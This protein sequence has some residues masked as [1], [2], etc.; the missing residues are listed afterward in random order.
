PPSVS[1]L[2]WTYRPERLYGARIGSQ[3]AP[4]WLATSRNQA[5]RERAVRAVRAER[6]CRARARAATPE[7]ARVGWCARRGW[8][9]A[10]RR[11]DSRWRRSRLAGTAP[12]GA[13]ARLWRHRGR[14]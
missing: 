10:V 5:R 8:Q 9:D 1:R 2:L 14:G 6:S 4:P 12:P 11:A 3:S 13:R 7:T